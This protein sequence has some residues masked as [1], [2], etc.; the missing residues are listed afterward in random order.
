[1][2]ASVTVSPRYASASRFSFC[3]IRAEIS[4]GVYF[5]P[6]ISMV[7]L[8]PMWRFTERMVRSTFVT[9]WRLATSPT[10]TS[11]F[12]AKATI[13]G[14]VRAPSALAITVASPPSRTLTQLFVVPRSIPTALAIYLLPFQVPLELTIEVEAVKPESILPKRLSRCDS[15][16]HWV[17]QRLRPEYSRPEYLQ[18]PR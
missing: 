15:G 3:K 18:V 9:D 8:V 10:R 12:L 2:T 4:C 17:E 13:D 5:F 16:L 7:Q 14:V 1:M 11:P 6:S